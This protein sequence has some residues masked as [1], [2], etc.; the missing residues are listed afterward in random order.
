MM[1]QL[2]LL[3]EAGALNVAVVVEAGRRDIVVVA[4]G[5]A[6]GRMVVEMDSLHDFLAIDGL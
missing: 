1:L 5:K 3:L 2:L 4:A 6:L